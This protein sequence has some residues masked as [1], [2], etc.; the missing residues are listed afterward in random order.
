MARFLEIEELFGETKVKSLIAVG[1]INYIFNYEGRAVVQMTKKFTVTT[2]NYEEVCELLRPFQ[3]NKT[4]L[5]GTSI[6][7]P[8]L[9][10][11]DRG[12]EAI[13]N[14]NRVASL[15][16]S[17]QG[18]IDFEDGSTVESNFSPYGS[19]NSLGLEQGDHIL[20]KKND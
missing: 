14:L 19:V 15:Y 2:N 9:N 3:F 16:G 20:R 10:T 18:E 4:E 5:N 11:K 1:L 6:H 7:A 13:I 17:W 12:V 8:R